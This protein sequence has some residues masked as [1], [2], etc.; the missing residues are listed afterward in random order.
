[1][2]QEKISPMSKDS[3]YTTNGIENTHVVFSSVYVADDFLKILDSHVGP[4]TRND[5]STVVAL[6][7]KIRHPA[8][9]QRIL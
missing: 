4:I 1:M 6:D 9:D 8:S 2:S 5:P 7:T 3:K